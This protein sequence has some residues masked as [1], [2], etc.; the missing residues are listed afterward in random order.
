MV[1]GQPAQVNLGH[2]G[3]VISMHR[4]LNHLQMG[5][6]E[7]ANSVML[8][9]FFLIV[10]LTALPWACKFW[11]LILR[12]GIAKLPLDAS[13]GFSDLNKLTFLRFQLPYLKIQPVLPSSQMWGYSCILTLGLFAITFML[14]SRWVPVVYLL[15]AILLIQ[16]SALLYFALI[17]ARFPHTPD[18]YMEG[19]I[20]SGAGLISAIPFLFGLTFYIFQ[21]SALKKISITI[22]TMTYLVVFL[23]FQMLLQALVLQKTVLFMP[24]LYVVF[25]MPLDV[26]LVIAIYSYGMTWT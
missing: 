6:G 15:R 3:G 18:S 22:F 10:W 8:V 21:I 4:A 25:G 17:P 5:P 23:P 24:L 26:M 7:V 1:A 13:L 12:M 20:T 9:I 11:S 19:L 2:R 14:S 16:A